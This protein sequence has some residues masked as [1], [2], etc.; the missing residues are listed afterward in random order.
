MLMY[1][2]G[3]TYYIPLVFCYCKFVGFIGIVVCTNWIIFMS[4]YLGT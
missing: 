3:F 1:R 4:L 2:F